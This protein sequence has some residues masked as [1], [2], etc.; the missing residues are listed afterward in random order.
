MGSE[1]WTTVGPQHQ[2]GLLIKVNV[3]HHVPEDAE[4]VSGRLLKHSADIDDVSFPSHT[5]QDR[6]Q[7][8]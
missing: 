3:F 7:S 2:S 1:A 4:D 6:P 5:P 8:A